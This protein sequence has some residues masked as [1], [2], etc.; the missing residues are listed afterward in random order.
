MRML[1]YPVDRVALPVDDP[2]CNRFHHG[3]EVKE[4]DIDVLR[5]SLKSGRA[6]GRSMPPRQELIQRYGAHG[7]AS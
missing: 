3:G 2:A 7:V 4:Q 1:S 5:L 6:Q